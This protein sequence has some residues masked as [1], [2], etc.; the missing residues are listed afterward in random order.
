MSWQLTFL[1][2][3]TRAWQVPTTKLEHVCQLRKWSCIS[4]VAEDGNKV[5]GRWQV[6]NE[7]LVYIHVG[8]PAFRV[9]AELRMGGRG[10]GTSTY[11]SEA[12]VNNVDKGAMITKDFE[13]RTEELHLHTECYR[14]NSRGLRRTLHS[15]AVGPTLRIQTTLT[16]INPS[17]RVCYT[18]SE[19]AS[20]C[21]IQTW[22]LRQDKV[23]W[24]HVKSPP[25]RRHLDMMM[26]TIKPYRNYSRQILS[27]S[28]ALGHLQDWCPWSCH[29]CRAGIGG[30]TGE[31]TIVCEHILYSGGVIQWS[32]H[33]RRKNYFCWCI[34]LDS[35]A[36]VGA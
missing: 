11:Q 30:W 33:T 13:P 9:R 6:G 12:C 22:L 27:A 4:M 16:Y 28:S 20:R 32:I 15:V 8:S 3:G 36:S 18:T 29:R 10:I 17:P 25:P 5:N 21:G 23:T 24:V 26:T 7:V 34:V 14:I 31:G 2:F 1:Y 35:C 19:G